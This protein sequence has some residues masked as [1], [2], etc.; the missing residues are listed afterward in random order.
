MRI[1]S[2]RKFAR[3]A[4]IIITLILLLLLTT[5]KHFL[6]DRVPNFLGEFGVIEAVEREVFDFSGSIYFLRVEAVE[7]LLYDIMLEKM[8]GDVGLNSLKEEDPQLFPRVHGHLFLCI[9]GTGEPSWFDIDTSHSGRLFN[10]NEK[11]FCFLDYET[12][13]LYYIE[14]RD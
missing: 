6:C 8:G 11:A 7:P 5:L 13:T 3:W 4:L 2:K 1:K 9:F 12:S 10:S 14:F